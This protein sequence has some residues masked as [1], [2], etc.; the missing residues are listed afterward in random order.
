MPATIWINLQNIVL[1]ENSQ[2]K[3]T[4]SVYASIYIKSP[5]QGDPETHMVPGGLGWEI[6]ARWAHGIFLVVIEMF[7]NWTVVVCTAL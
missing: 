5:A 6:D 7:S 3:T 1:S 2:T 4:T